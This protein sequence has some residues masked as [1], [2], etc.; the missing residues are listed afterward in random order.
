M[1]A[2]RIALVVL[3]FVGMSLFR[4]TQAQADVAY[5]SGLHN[6]FGTL[7][8]STGVFTQIGVFG[9]PNNGVM[10]GLGSLGPGL[11]D[12]VDNNGEAY[13]INTGNASTK[14]LGNTGIIPLGGFAGYNSQYIF[15]LDELYRV[16]VNNL[17]TTLIATYNFESDGLLAVGPDGSVYVASFDR[18]G[19][20]ADELFKINP[21]T[22]L[23]VD[24]GSTGDTNLFAGT[25]V[26]G[27]LYGFDS[28]GNILKLNTSDGEGTVVAKYQL[29]GG[30]AIYAAG[31][32]T[33]VVPEPSSVILAAIGGI[34]TTVVLRRRRLSDTTKAG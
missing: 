8:L 12:G 1:S 18:N 5:V 30:D 11:L 20:A 6:E 26:G 29:P 3:V 2:H 25:F 17:S 21:Y 33:A 13:S 16:N 4:S 31:S 7:D 23:A 19:I 9:L 34:L 32:T 28:T 24:L 15:T 27:T 22:G 10:F 14:D